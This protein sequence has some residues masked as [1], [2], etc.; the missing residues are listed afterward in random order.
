MRYGYIRVSTSDQNIDRQL[1][2]ISLD[3]CCLPERLSG[4][5]TDRPILQWLLDNIK[6]GDEIIVH[7]L[8]RLSRSLKDM[9][10]ISEKIIS[11]GA[12]LTAGNYRINANDPNS[13]LV[14]K[15]LAVVAE[16]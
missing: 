2:G 9:L 5:N 3:V 16:W 10:D 7:S 4:K 11:K 1:D 6:P 12:S 8:D 15:I 14:M 13:Q